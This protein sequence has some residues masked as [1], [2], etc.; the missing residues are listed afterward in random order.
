MRKISAALLVSVMAVL[1][2]VALAQ[3][4]EFNSYERRLVQINFEIMYGDIAPYTRRF[5]QEQV[6][7]AARQLRRYIRNDATLQAGAVSVTEN[8]LTERW[9]IRVATSYDTAIAPIPALSALI[10][11]Y[12]GIEIF[13]HNNEVLNSTCWYTGFVQGDHGAD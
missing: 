12:A 4:V 6:E 1:L 3:A 10:D 7:A 2:G 5:S 9:V 13:V 8:Y 11:A